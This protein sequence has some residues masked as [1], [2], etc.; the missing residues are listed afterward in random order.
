[1][2]DTI[3]DRCSNRLPNRRIDLIENAGAVGWHDRR[4]EDDRSQARREGPHDP[5]YGHAG[6]G[7]CDEDDLVVEIRG[8]DVVEDRPGAIIEGHPTQVDVGAWA[9][10]G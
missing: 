1:M 6:E 3:D 9:A 2:I 8:V 7:M 5:G 10:T 4:E